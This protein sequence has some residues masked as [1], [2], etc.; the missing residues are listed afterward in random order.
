MA[1]VEKKV[2]DGTGDI[3]DRE[4]LYEGKVTPDGGNQLGKARLDSKEPDANDLV[5]E[6]GPDEEKD[7]SVK[8]RESEPE[9][10]IQVDET[11]SP[12]SCPGDIS[13]TSDEEKKVESNE[14]D[15]EEVKVVEEKESCG[16]LG[17][18]GGDQVE[19]VKGNK[20]GDSKDNEK[21]EEKD[22]QV[23]TFEEFKKKHLEQGGGQAGQ[24]PPDQG[25]AGSSSAK[26]TTLT[27]Y[28]S[29]D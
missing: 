24:R 4:A 17:C 29:V 22:D 7:D 3:E 16:E 28:A 18:K 15:I 25:T 1:E 8:S 12:N 11:C 27:N 14:E 23:L 19:E 26:K 6:L 10:S 21:D 2:G 5:P 20:D 9:K 13:Y